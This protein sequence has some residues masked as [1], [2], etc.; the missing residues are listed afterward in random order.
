MFARDRR[1][2]K[3]F[4]HPRGRGTVLPAWGVGLCARHVA[5]RETL[6]DG[7]FGWGGTSV[8]A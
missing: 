6:P 8:K 1:L 7:E 3:P 2:G 4:R 5:E